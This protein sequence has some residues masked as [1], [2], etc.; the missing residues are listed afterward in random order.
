MTIYKKS[1]EMILNRSFSLLYVFSI[2]LCVCF[3]GE[4]VVK[5]NKP[6]MSSATDLALFVGTG[7]AE[8]ELSAVNGDEL[9]LAGDCHSNR[10][11]SSVFHRKHFADGALAFFG[12]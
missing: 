11:G 5:D 10:C 8:G 9:A 12:V 1:V 7:D 3:L 2:K 4:A 6:L